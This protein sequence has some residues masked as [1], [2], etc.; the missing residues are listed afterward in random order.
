[1]LENEILSILRLGAIGTTLPRDEETTL[2]ICLIDDM[3]APGFTC[4]YSVEECESYLD[5]FR[6]FSGWHNVLKE[7]RLAELVADDAQCP[8]YRTSAFGEF[9]FSY[10]WNNTKS[11]HIVSP[12]Q[13][14]Y[15]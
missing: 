2:L 3:T 4:P 1:M 8:S 14:Q 6:S 5:I 13:G 7:A 10:A 9:L 15:W 12:D 11:E